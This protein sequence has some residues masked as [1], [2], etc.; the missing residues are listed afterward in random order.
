MGVEAGSIGFVSS[1][2]FDV[3]SAKA[4]GFRSHWLN[5]SGAAAEEL[6]TTPDVTLQSFSDLTNLI[7]P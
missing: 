6:G 1:N 7:K 3:V 2:L 4:F 5:G